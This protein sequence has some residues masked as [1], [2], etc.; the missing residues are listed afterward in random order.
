MK[1]TYR[2]DSMK[3]SVLLILLFVAAVILL[4]NGAL[5]A[6]EGMFHGGDVIY[7]EPVKAVIFSHKV[8]AEDMGMGCD[9]CHAGLFEMA[10]LSAQSNEDF[11][12][13]GLYDGK[14]CGSCHNGQFAFASDTQC[15]RC[16]IGVI[17]S[18]KESRKKRPPINSTR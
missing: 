7:T 16:H 4:A 11:T 5:M 1:T 2:G 3:K 17:T 15:A 12:M 9:M 6:S 14:Y 13:Q 18:L 10:S 8:H